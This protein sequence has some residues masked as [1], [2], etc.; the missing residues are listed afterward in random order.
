MLVGHCVWGGIVLS[1]SAVTQQACDDG[2]ADWTGN[3]LI[4]QALVYIAV[5]AIPFTMRNK[6]NARITGVAYL[7]LAVAMFVLFLSKFTINGKLLSNVTVGQ[8]LLCQAVYE[9]SQPTMWAFY[10][11][12]NA[13]GA[14]GGL[15]VLIPSVI[16][17]GATQQK[18]AGVEG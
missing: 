11:A 2:L 17:L 15:F 1:D 18:C 7:A 16:F 8:D 4:V 5:A 10:Q 12:T 3:V 6:H 14:T 13:L 9:N